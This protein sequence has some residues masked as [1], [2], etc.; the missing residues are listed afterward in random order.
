MRVRTLLIVMACAVLGVAGCAKRVPPPAPAPTPVAAAPAPPPPPPPPPAPAPEPAEAP[1]ALT[2]DE[3][4]ARQTLEELNAAMPLTDVFFDYDQAVLRDEAR[5]ALL[6]NADWLRRWSSTRIAIEG[7]CDS[8]GT[9]EYNLA[10]GD[11]RA[12][13]VKSYLIGLGIPPDRLLVVSKGEETPFCHQESEACWQQNRRGHFI[14]TA[15]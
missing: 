9:N 5:P 1:R 13:A 10:L 6:R 7:H 14:I 11:R 2:E 15:K 4:F 3:L 12:E 8:R